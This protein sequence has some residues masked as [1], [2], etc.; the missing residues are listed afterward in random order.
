MTSYLILV[1]LIGEKR[2]KGERKIR[3]ERERKKK[4]GR[5]RKRKGDNGPRKLSCGTT[6]GRWEAP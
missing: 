3:R 4:K 2:K 5:G 1:D 6:T